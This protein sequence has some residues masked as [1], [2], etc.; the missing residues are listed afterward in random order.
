MLTIHS[1]LRIIGPV[2]L[3]DESQILMLYDAK[4]YQNSLKSFRVIVLAVRMMTCTYAGEVSYCTARV[5]A[6]SPV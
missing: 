5:N 4:F 3:E 1:T 2:D 6:V